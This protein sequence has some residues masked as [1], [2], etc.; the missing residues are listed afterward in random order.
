MFNQTQEFI[1]DETGFAL[2]AWPVVAPK[3]AASK[4]AAPARPPRDEAALAG[5][6]QHPGVWR[7]RSSNA[8]TIDAQPSGLAALDALLPGGGWPR[9][10]LCEFLVEHDG[11]GECALVLPALAALT[12]ARRRVALITPPYLPYAPALAAAGVDLQQVVQIDAGTPDTHWSIEQC[13]R[14]G[15]CGAVLGW[16]PRVDYRELRRLQLAAESGGTIG[17]MF[18]PLAAAN[19]ASPSALRLRITAAQGE[20]RIEL[21]KCRGRVGSAACMPSGA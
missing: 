13:L 11:I 10:A 2:P 4:M 17:F 9:G 3:S 7:R 8:T 5:V 18:R 19:E 20:P 1:A 12:Q 14:S 15:C 21:L 16:L 6:L